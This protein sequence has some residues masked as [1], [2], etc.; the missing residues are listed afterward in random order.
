LARVRVTIGA[1]HDTDLIGV[2]RKLGLY[3]GVVEGRYKCFVCG[4]RITLEN[5]GG[6]F[7][8]KDEKINFVCDN[9]KCLITAAEITSKINREITAIQSQTQLHTG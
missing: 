3:E 4:R 7:R 2:L 5:I 1:I 6:I 8:S 9:I